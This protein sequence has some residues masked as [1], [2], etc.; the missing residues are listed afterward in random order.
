MSKPSRVDYG[1]WQT[2]YN[3]ALSICQQLKSQGANPKVIVEPTCGVG[4]F[5]L[6]ALEVF[7]NID[8]V[9]GIEIHQ[10]YLEE[11]SKTL[12]KKYSG[13]IPSHI[14]L[15]NQNIFEFSS[16]SLAKSCKEKEVLIL[17]NPP[18][19]TN[20]QLSRLSSTNVP[21][22]GNFRNQKGID[23]MTGKG[24]FDIGETIFLQMLDLMPHIRGSIAILLKNSVIKNILHSQK[25]ER[26][27]I[28]NIQ[29]HRIDASREFG[30]AVAASLFIAQASP[31]PAMQCKVYDF[32]TNNHTHTYGWIHD[33]FVANTDTYNSHKDIDGICPLTWR[34][35]VKHDCSK[36]MELGK[37]SDGYYNAHGQQVDIEEDLIFPLVKSSDINTSNSGI[38]RRYILITQHRT[39]EETAT[40]AITHPKAYQYL[41]E[42]ASE[43]D[44]RGSRIYRGRPRFAIFGIGDYSFAPY[45][46]IVSGLYKHTYFSYFG[47]IEKPYMADDTCYILPFQDRE[48]AIITQSILNH[49]STQAFI[50]SILF[51][52][53]KRV[54]SKDLLERIDLIAAARKIGHKELNISSN[55]L[56]KYIKTIISSANKGATQL[57][58][59]LTA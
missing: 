12:K 56:E 16:L 9:Y 27:N 50:R 38:T 53:A 34:S 35:G 42:H 52:D 44:N 48:T 8:E 29:Q 40:L 45:K 5:I 22:K 6:A 32:Y 23:A 1:D 10:P 46:V 55:E 4:N 57:T 36:V 24:N 33:K 21:V 3:L 11:L 39:S 47:G 49:K 28:A 19:V 30:A 20:S 2:N 25:S 41:E 17:G 15:I 51:E 31:E 58:L 59:S 13:N 37:N 43:L 18:W 54:I 7:D 26:L 14:H